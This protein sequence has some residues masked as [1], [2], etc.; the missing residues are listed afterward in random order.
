MICKYYSILPYIHW[1]QSLLFQ[2]AKNFLNVTRKTDILFDSP[3]IWKRYLPSNER[4]DLLLLHDHIHWLILRILHHGRHHSWNVK[5]LRTGSQIS[6][7]VWLRDLFIGYSQL[8]KH[9]QEANY[10]VHWPPRWSIR[11]QRWFSL[12]SRVPQSINAPS[13]FAKVLLWNAYKFSSIWEFNLEWSGI[14]G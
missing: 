1:K 14:H 3:G 6:R 8:S 4:R 12:V 7:K 10:P 9:V 2:S 5:D 13:N 11:S